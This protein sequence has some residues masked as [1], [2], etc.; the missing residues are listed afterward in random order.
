MHV[1]L[2]FFAFLSVLRGEK[3]EKRYFTAKGAKEREGRK[4]KL[5][6]HCV[7][8]LFAFLHAM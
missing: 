8:R 3:K 7:M 1:F 2:P 4:P 6:M 5:E